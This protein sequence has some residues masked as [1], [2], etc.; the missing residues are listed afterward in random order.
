MSQRL[1][2]DTVFQSG[3]TG[4]MSAAL[5]HN[6][7]VIQLSAEVIAAGPGQSREKLKRIREDF[8]RLHKDYSN[9]YKRVTDE[10][11]KA[12]EEGTI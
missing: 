6:A 1:S 10:L 12:I 8:T 2:P 4:L 9:E 7:L 5:N 3:L 11:Q